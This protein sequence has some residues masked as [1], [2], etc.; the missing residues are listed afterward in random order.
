HAEALVR[1]ALQQHGRPG[2]SEMPADHLHR[3]ALTG[4]VR[5]HDRVHLANVHPE[6]D[7][8]QDLAPLDRRVEMLDL[9]QGAFPFRLPA[10]PHPPHPTLPSR[11]M[12]RS[13]CASTANSIGSSLKTSLQKPFTIMFTASSF[14]RP[15]C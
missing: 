15:R 1:C 6:I 5:S 10:P 8:P 12:P 3:R 7:A 9:E 4:A 13:R 11:L 2:I 14:A